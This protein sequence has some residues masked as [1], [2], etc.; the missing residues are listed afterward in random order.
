M[1]N[2]F[3]TTFRLILLLIDW[4]VLL[5]A[6]SLAYLIRFG[7]F[8]RTDFL[9][10]DYIGV[11]MLVSV[12]WL[13]FLVGFRVYALGRTFTSAFHIK[14]LILAN[15][16]GVAAFI[17]IFFFWRHQFYSRLIIVYLFLLSTVFLIAIHFLAN[18]VRMYLASKNIG[19]TRTLIIGSNRVAEETIRR[20]KLKKSNIQP[21]SI[22]DAYGATVDEIFDVPV[23]GKLNKLEDIVQKR[24]I[25]LI[26]Q[27]DNIEHTLNLIAFAEDKGIEYRMVPSL[28]G[29]FHMA[30][31]VHLEDRPVIRAART[32]SLPEM[33]FGK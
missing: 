19:I 7:T 4:F 30:E 6:F 20:L 11:A 5:G 17:M 15:I 32:R 3:N 33:I 1:K 18:R 9:F 23:E 13:V 25:E 26:L 29:M 31:E 16:A 28:L 2:K 14:R 22:L 8:S 10:S 24:K 12:L 27:T 21:V